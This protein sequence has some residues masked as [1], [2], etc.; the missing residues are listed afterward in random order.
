MSLGDGAEP[1]GRRR[2]SIPAR[3]FAC[4]PYMVVS[5]PA[6]YLVIGVLSVRDAINSRCVRSSRS[7]W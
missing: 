4:S 1:S 6:T 7:C 3:F 5:R 2:V